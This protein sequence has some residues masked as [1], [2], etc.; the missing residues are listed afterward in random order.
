MG[1]N[2]QRVLAVVNHQSDAGKTTT[3]MNLGASLAVA[4]KSVLL[5]DLDPV[6]SLSF[7]L[8]CDLG[9]DRRRLLS[10]LKQESDINY[11]IQK[12]SISNL[13]VLAATDDYARFEVVAMTWE[14]KEY[15][16]KEV[17]SK[18]NKQ[19]QYVII[20]TP[21]AVG[22][23]FINALVAA[24]EVLIPVPCSAGGGRS[25]FVLAECVD[26]VRHRFNPDLRDEK[27]VVNMYD[28]RKGA[29]HRAFEI[30]KKEFEATLF[31]TVVPSSPSLLANGQAGGIA[32][33]ANANCKSAGAFLSLAAEV[34]EGGLT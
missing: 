31:R 4:E 3:A 28:P 13:D 11:A 25:L 15:A 18:I 2:L 26:E 5:V 12:T 9:G 16:L 29:S 27:Y 7:R 33:L 24:D 8:N 14:R 23:A 10:V 1:G 22:V 21:S 32:V 6:A 20:D 17:F 19:Y 34:S 30:L